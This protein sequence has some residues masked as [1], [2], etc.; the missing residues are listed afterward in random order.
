M[1][2]GIEGAPAPVEAPVEVEE[3]TG[4]KRKVSK[5]EDGGEKKS[6][7]SGGGDD[8]VVIDET[9]KNYLVHIQTELDKMRPV[10]HAL[11]I[12][13]KL[14]QL[15]MDTILKTGIPIGGPGQITASNTTPLPS[16]AAKSASAAGSG[17]GYGGMPSSAARDSK[18]A[19]SP[20][21][22]QVA[23][24]SGTASAIAAR[25]TTAPEVPHPRAHA[26]PPA[27]FAASRPRQPAHV[28]RTQRPACDLMGPETD[29]A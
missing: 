17:S 11:P 15:E 26:L 4:A 14:L 6:K 21:T 10:A 1:V 9:N 27:A 8:A 12:C 18:P 13:A 28:P 2:E 5:W 22:F 7:F 16:T 29:Q 25:G 3:T 19:R 20:S 24:N 23:A